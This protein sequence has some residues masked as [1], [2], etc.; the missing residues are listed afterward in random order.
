MA[1][2]AFSKLNL[3]PKYDEAVPVQ[4]GEVTVTVKKYLPAQEK[5][6]LI[7]R[8]VTW[9]HEEDYYFANPVKADIITAIEVLLAYTD[10]VFTDK[11]KEDIPKL[12]DTCMTNGLFDIIFSAIPDKE[13]KIIDEGIA[14]TIEAIYKYQNSVMGI[15]EQVKTDYDA[16][17][18]DIDNLAKQLGNKENIEFVKEL[19]DK[20]G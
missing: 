2:I 11:Q 16:T 19:M 14:K 13:L 5:L 20:M 17:S 6:R 15:L 9:A 10:I 18:F 7:G 4:I 12:F 8:V 3:K 1:K